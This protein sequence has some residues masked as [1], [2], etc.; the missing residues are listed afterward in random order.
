VT[1]ACI[2]S[3]DQ[4]AAQLPR[5]YYVTKGAAGA[6]AM[7]CIMSVGNNTAAG[8]FNLLPQQALAIP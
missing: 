2:A 6:A 3:A 7:L 4:G 1:K 8:W 5:H